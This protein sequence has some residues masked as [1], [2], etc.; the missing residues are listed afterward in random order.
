MKTNEGKI[1]FDVLGHTVTFRP[2]IDGSDIAPEQI[3]DYVRKE[4]NIIKRNSPNLDSGQI[5]VLLALKLAKENFDLKND[6]KE[7][8]D[9][10][11]AS[12]SDALQYFEE[13]APTIS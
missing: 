5:A 13:V 12:A 11:S 8:I 6:F 1:E 4:A 7:N 2:N 9:K 3:L 10:L